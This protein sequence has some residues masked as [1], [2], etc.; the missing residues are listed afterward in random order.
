[1]D[2]FPLFEY[3]FVLIYSFILLNLP[4][5]WKK[6]QQL[7]S[8]VQN[9]SNSSVADSNVFLAEYNCGLKRGCFW[10][11]ADCGPI[12]CLHLCPIEPILYSNSSDSQHSGPKSDHK[13]EL[14]SLHQLFLI[15]CY[16]LIQIIG[17]AIFKYNK[18]LFC[19]TFVIKSKF[20]NFR[21]ANLDSRSLFYFIHVVGQM[22]QR[23]MIP[24]SF[25]HC[26]LSR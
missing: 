3:V 16:L 21:V 1:M 10:R 12:N 9:Y 20:L 23:L 6:A 7:Q 4:E 24:I 11:Y 26:I 5:I 13:Y 17:S 18:F 14:V 8:G 22:A 15:L 2:S 25:Y 19:I